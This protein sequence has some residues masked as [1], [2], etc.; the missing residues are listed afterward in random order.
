MG[1]SCRSI[2]IAGRLL[3][4]PLLLCGESDNPREVLGDVDR[5]EVTVEVRRFRGEE[6]GRRRY[7]TM[8]DTGDIDRLDRK[9]VVSGDMLGSGA[10]RAA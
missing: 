4:L 8:G 7:G 10:G 5:S 1:A 9:V 6:D 3:R 2:G